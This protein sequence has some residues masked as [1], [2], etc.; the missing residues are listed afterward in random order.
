S[1]VGPPA[2][3]DGRGRGGMAVGRHGPAPV[4]ATGANV[5]SHGAGGLASIAGQEGFDDGQVLVGLLGEAVG[6]IAGLI[7]FPGNIPEGSEED[8]QSADFLGQQGIAARFGDEIVQPAIEGAG[9]CDEAAAGSCAGGLEPAEVFGE[10][11]QGSE[12]DAAAG[13]AGGGT[14]EDAS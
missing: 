13:A 3:S 9:L 7:L 14:F 5:P 2:A 6:G 12:V 1:W 10:S 11:M 4:A 8:L